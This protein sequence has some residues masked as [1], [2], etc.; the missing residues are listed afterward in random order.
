M[1]Q[2][3]KQKHQPLKSGKRLGRLTENIFPNHTQI[4]R[5]PKTL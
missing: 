5:Q 2:N 4:S 3:S 1:S